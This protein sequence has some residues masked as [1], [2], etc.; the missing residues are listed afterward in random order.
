MREAEPAKVGRV[1]IVGN[2]VTKDRVI[3]RVLG[4]YPGQTLRYPELRIAERDLARLGI[5]DIGPE[6]RP[7][8]TV[9]ETDSEYKDI[10][11]QVKETPTGSLMFGAG[12][13]SDAGFVG[14]V[15]LNEKNFDLFRFPQSFSEI[16]EGKAFRG[17]G[18]ELRIEAIPGTELQ[19]Y[20][21]SFREP[22]LFDRPIS[23]TD[24]VYYYDR[25][26]PEDKET[27]VGGRIGL[28]KQ[29]TKEW[30]VGV[31]ARAENVKIG[32]LLF[33]APPAYTDVFGNNFI[34]GPRV[35]LTYDTRDSFMRPTEGG[36]MEFSYE[37]MFGD[38][39]F[40]ILNFEGSRYFTT[41][42]RADGSGKHVLAARTQVAWCGDETPV[43]ER[44]YAGGFRSLRGFQFRGANPFVN[45]Y[46][47]G[48]QFL[49]L[50]SLEY[51]VPILAND[52]LYAVAFIDS[53]TVESKVDLSNY[54]VSAGVGLRISVP[55][56]GPVPI[57]LD[58]GFP[59]VRAPDDKT[60]VFSFWV[61]MFR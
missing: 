11:V 5:F 55:M 56:L 45:G 39:T 9:L 34:A 12:I 28:T 29:I 21:I 48:G 33:G 54:R 58:F 13:N 35:S 18:Q 32:N 46:A 16:F 20:T 15:V 25:I 49:F 24:S 42:Q 47:V 19:R 17:A 27:R 3:R 60:Q 6:T 14:S 1:I 26:Y 31:S 36:L 10:L 37:Q 41:Y 4:L 44:F 61:G 50:N 38:F 57:A 59:I 52:Q 53:G 51:Q 7:S 40:P 30:A 22:F 43:F 23:F 8:L 2:E